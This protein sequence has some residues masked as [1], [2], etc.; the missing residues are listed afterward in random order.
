MFRLCIPSLRGQTILVYIS[1]IND[2]FS[3]NIHGKNDSEYKNDK[4]ING[5]VK[6]QSGLFIVIFP[7]LLE[8]KHIEI[9]RLFLKKIALSHF[10][11]SSHFIT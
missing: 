8:E 5:Q 7:F 10:M 11:C 1:K 9:I 3:K 4:G 6:K 2:E